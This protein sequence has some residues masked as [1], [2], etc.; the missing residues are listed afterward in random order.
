M[1]IYVENLKN[2]DVRFKV[3]SYDK[4]TKIAKLKG[5]YGAEFTR[6]ISKEALEKFGYKLVKSENE[7]PLMSA[8]KPKPPKE[9]K[10]V[11]AAP[12][13]EEDEEE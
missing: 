5:E 6:D 4:A 1:H 7:L 11:K 10:V 9:K 8:P 2:P 13:E 12:P 3:M